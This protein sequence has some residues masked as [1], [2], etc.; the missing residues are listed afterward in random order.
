MLRVKHKLTERQTTL[1]GEDG[2]MDI[3][4][5]TRVGL[6]DVTV[7]DGV[8]VFLLAELQRNG[9]PT[10]TALPCQGP[11]VGTSVEHTDRLSGLPSAYRDA[12]E[13]ALSR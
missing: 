13:A 11:Y 8:L 12:A 5:R 2:V 4:A 6:A 7:G 10:Y 1:Y 3:V 9:S